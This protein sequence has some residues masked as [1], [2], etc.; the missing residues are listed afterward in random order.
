VKGLTGNILSVL[1]LLYRYRKP[2]KTKIKI[3]AFPGLVII[4]TIETYPGTG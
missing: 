3:R 4:V 2:N 1:S